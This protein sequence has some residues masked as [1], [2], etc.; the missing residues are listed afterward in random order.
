MKCV[1]LAG[2]RGT[3]ISEESLVKPKPMVEVG[4][5]PILWH[6][7]KIY[8][9]HGVTDFVVCLGYRGYVVKE[10]FANY[11]LHKSDVSIDM[12][13]N[14]M[15]FHENRSEPW[16]VTLVETGAETQTGGRLLRA[17]RYVGDDTFCLTYGDG[18]ADVDVQ[19]QIGFHQHHGEIATMTV[20]HPPARFGS[21]ALSED[22]VTAFEEKPQTEGG[23]V[24]GG[25]FVLEPA[26][27]D[28]IEGDEIALEREPLRHLAQ[29]GQL[30]A[31]VH[32]GFWQPM[33]TLREKVLLDKLWNSGLAPWKS[34]T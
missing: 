21:A 14:D 28:L 9:E 16:R 34:W 1:I 5:Q 25:F 31:W 10:Y 2:G 13:T 29:Q 26:I 15:E 19:A 22:R 18:L 4:E 7:M 6:I 24:N 20:V 11:F 8:A 30:R 3:R 23:Y 33:D 32:S 12:R 27:F 17:R